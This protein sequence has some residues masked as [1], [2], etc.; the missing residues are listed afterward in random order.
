M[1]EE[2][3]KAAGKPRDTDRGVGPDL[4]AG[5]EERLHHV[6][7]VASHRVLVGV[8]KPGA[9]R[10]ADPGVR[11]RGGD[12]RLLRRS[13]F[14]AV[15]R[16]SLLAAEHRTVARAGAR[17]ADVTLRATH[18][19]R[20]AAAARPTVQALPISAAIEAVIVA[21]AWCHK[22]GRGRRRARRAHEQQQH[23]RYD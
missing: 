9:I 23:E 6:A 4:P 3:K 11:A 17:L 19:L 5:L 13:P 22:C 10:V 20:R 21:E 12:A 15:V 7:G 2:K 18:A 1:Q 16:L 14:F 8:G